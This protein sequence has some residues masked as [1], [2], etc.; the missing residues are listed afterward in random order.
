MR[1]C[2]VKGSILKRGDILGKVK[3]YYM[4]YPDD[5]S[6]RTAYFNFLLDI[7]NKNGED[8][9]RKFLLKRLFNKEYKWVIPNDENRAI[10]G[11]KLRDKFGYY[12]DLEGP[13]SIL[14]MMVALA[15]RCENDIMRDPKYGDRTGVWFWIMM[16]NLGLMEYKDDEWDADS[17]WEID[18]ICASFVSN[19]Y[20]KS[21]TGGLFLTRNPKIDMRKKEIWTQL[22]VYLDEFL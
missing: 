5:T 12:E 15:I 3:E 20:K 11:T 21:G 1:L 18:Q 13:C 8:R 7:I 4:N 17:A 10:D 19:K 22:G 16:R 14:E 6:M 9:N 2:D